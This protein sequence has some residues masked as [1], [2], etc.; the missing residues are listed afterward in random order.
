MKE[1]D[2]DILIK[3]NQDLRYANNNLRGVVAVL[4]GKYREVFMELQKLQRLVEH[5][6]GTLN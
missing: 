5:G 4:D 2:V 3:E 1:L 6:L